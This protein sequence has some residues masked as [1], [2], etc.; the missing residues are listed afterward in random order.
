MEICAYHEAGHALMAVMLG[1]RVQ[2]LTIEPEWD[3]ETRREGD[4][5]VHW[6]LDEFT[7]RRLSNACITVALAGPAAEM[8]HREM[9]TLGEPFHPALMREWAYDWQVAWSLAG[10]FLVDEP[11][12]LAFLESSLMGLY[13]TLRSDRMWN[14]LAAIV[15]ELVAHE[16]LDGPDVHEIVST[17]IQ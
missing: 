16:T 8:I 5:E 7:D 17:W 11:Q 14:A 10:K 15:D 4:V 2:R 12:R 6:P 1:G 3:E 9:V 13:Q